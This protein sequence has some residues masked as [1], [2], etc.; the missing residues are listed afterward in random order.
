[1]ARAAP[2]PAKDSAYKPSEHEP[3]L[4]ELWESRGYFRGVADRGKEPYAISMP[5]PNI[6]G[7]LHLGH[8]TAG[9]LEDILVRYARMQGKA[10][11]LIPGTDHAAIAT[12]T[13]VERKIADEQGKT[14][15]DLGR[16][17]FLKEVRTFVNDTQDQIKNQIRRLG[18]S[19]DWSRERYTMD[20]HM[21]RAVNEAFVRLYNDGLIYRGKRIISWCPRCA[22][23][24]SDIEVDYA[25]VPGSL[26]YIKYPVVQDGK[27]SLERTITVATTR[28]ETMLGDQAVAVHPEDKRYHDLIGKHV[29]LPLVDKEIPIVGD[30]HV[31]QN[32]GTGAVKVT[33]AHDLADYDIAQRHGLEAINVIGESGKMIEP[34]PKDF[35]GMEVQEARDAVVLRLQQL[36]F[37]ERVD[38]A[39]HNVPTCS[40]CDTRVQPLVSD[41]W[42]VKVEPLAKKALAAVKSGKTTFVPERFTQDFYR[43]MENIHDW[44][45]SRQIWWGHRIPVYTCSTCK[46]TIVSATAPGKCTATKSCAGHQFEQDPDT[47]DTWFSS[48]LWTFATL[49]WPDKTEELDFWHPTA[50]METGRDLIFFWVARMLML[51]TYLYGEEPFKTVYMHG[52]VLD[53]HGKKMSKSK[54]NVIDPLVVA[55]RYGMDAVRMSLVLGVSP[56]VDTRLSEEKIAGFR[57]FANKLWNVAAFVRKQA[58]ASSEPGTA[59]GRNPSDTLDLSTAT[60]FDQWIIDRADTLVAETSRALDE[61]RFSDAGQLIFSF[62]WNDF[63]DWYV[64]YAK[65]RPGHTTNAVLANVLDTVLKLLHPFM[66]FV[67]EAVWQTIKRPGTNGDPDLIVAPWPEANKD[68]RQ[69]KAVQE[70]EHLRELVQGLRNLRSDYSI[71]AST[72]MQVA[73][74]S[75]EFDDVITKLAKVEFAT[76]PTLDG[77]VTRTLAGQTVAASVGT[78]V[79]VKNESA[80]IGKELDKLRS[81]HEGIRARLKSKIFTQKAPAKVVESERTRGKELAGK[82]TSLERIAAEL[83][84][85]A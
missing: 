21:S 37:L 67:T 48:G 39:H 29:L 5:P 76:T 53:E 73:M 72:P 40:R 46:G 12:Q 41:Q 20:E 61:Y 36:G 30:A 26:W 23:G 71:P 1:V 2:R 56:G 51:T 25:E 82:I 62:L 45:I 38:D 75:G 31:D 77:A 69:P 66:P 42:F 55:D 14:R 3:K 33:P 18:V 64:E 43:W 10:A 70:V 24:L 83:A 34:A 47:L 35:A 79:D 84:D 80:R 9:T 28:P 54:G 57:N 49:G 50:V 27:W 68:L 59:H 78:F 8:A 11:V 32:F 15:H 19:C 63:A 22:S 44:N 58:A 81:I 6:T 74:P 52:L 60:L 85:L 7:R 4:Y 13:V 16:E 17:A 65:L